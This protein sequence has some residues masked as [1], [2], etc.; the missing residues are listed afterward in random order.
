MAFLVVGAASDWVV[1]DLSWS[2]ASNEVREC[3]SGDVSVLVIV[4]EDA[5]ADIVIVTVPEFTTIVVG[6]VD[7][8]SISGKSNSASV[9][10]CSGPSVFCNIPGTILFFADSVVFASLWG[11][12]RASS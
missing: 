8:K 6:S 2:I 12:S 11:L 3:S 1:L 5:I 4:E 9:I 7:D 10:C